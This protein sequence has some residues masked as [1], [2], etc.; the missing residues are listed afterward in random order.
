MLEL[1]QLEHGVRLSHRI[2]DGVRSRHDIVPLEL[3]A[4]LSH[5]ALITLYALIISD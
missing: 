5:T 2:C 3:H 4:Y 1:R